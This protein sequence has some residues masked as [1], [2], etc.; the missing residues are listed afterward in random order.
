[1]SGFKNYF[2]SFIVIF[3]LSIVDLIEMLLRVLQYRGYAFEGL[4][5]VFTHIHITHVHMFTYTHTQGVGAGKL[6]TVFILYMY[7]HVYYTSLLRVVYSMHAHM[8]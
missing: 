1:M 5:L 8:L 2:K 7:T 4:Y 3:G 6:V